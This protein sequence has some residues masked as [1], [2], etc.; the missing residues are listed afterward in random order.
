[1]RALGAVCLS[2]MLLYGAHWLDE[3][4]GA[5]KRDPQGHITEVSLRETWIMDSDLLELGRSK[6]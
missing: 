2:S 3:S 6:P 5:V 1:M 4:G